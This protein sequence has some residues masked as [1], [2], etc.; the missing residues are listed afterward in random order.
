[1]RRA[2]TIALPVVAITVLLIGAFLERSPGDLMWVPLV[3]ASTAVGSLLWYRRAGGPIGPLL[4][5]V[6][7]S[8]AVEVALSGYVQRAT[9]DGLPAANWV[10]WVFQSTML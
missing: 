2:V 9:T 4:A 1:M 7:A 6:G 8:V 5:F 3:A 10:A